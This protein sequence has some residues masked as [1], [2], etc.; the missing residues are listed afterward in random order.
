V[1]VELE[2]HG[3]QE[4][5]VPGAELSRTV[6]WFTATHPVRLDLSDVDLA[7]VLDGGAEVGRVV[8]RVKERL[9]AVP[10]HGLGYGLLRHVHGELDGLAEPQLGFNYLGRFTGGDATAPAATGWTEAPEL[11]GFGGTTDRRLPAANVLDVNAVTEDGPDGPVLSATWTY[12]AG[13][14]ADDEVRALAELWVTALAAIAAHV[15]AGHGG[16]HTPSDMALVDLD[17]ADLDELEAE[18]GTQ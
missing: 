8:K 7:D 16:G 13:L 2:G 4:E 5:A 6:G 3:R 12:P 17:Q 11:A 9:R 18:W 15:A 14:L 10:G 1:L